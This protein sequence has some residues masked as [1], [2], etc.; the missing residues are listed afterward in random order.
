MPFQ[1]K[2]PDWHAEGVEP[3]ES[4]RNTGW[5]PGERPPAEYW[6]WQMNRTYKVLQE[7]QQKA[8]EKVEVQQAQQTANEAKAT[9]DAAQ[10]DL[11]A[12]ASATTDVHGATSAATPNTIIQR[13][14]SGRAKVAAPVE[15]DDIARKAEVD[16]HASRTDNPHNTTAAQVGALPKKSFS[17][18][19]YDFN[20]RGAGSFIEEIKN[21]ASITIQ[22]GPSGF[23]S[24]ALIQTEGSHAR[25][26][27]QIAIEQR[28]RIFFR[29][30]E[31]ASG[32]LTWGQWNELAIKNDYVRV[33]GYAA[34][35][36]SAN[37]YTVTLNPAPTSYTDG[38]CVA[39]KINTTNTGASTLNV[40][41]LGAKPIKKPN[42]NDVAAGNLKAG[43]IYTLRY[44]ATT[45][46]FILQGE[47]GDFSVGDT[48]TETRLLPVSG[49][50]GAEIWA[51]TDVAYG[52]SI[53][54]DS[55][56]YVYCAHDVSSGKAIRKLDSSGN[57][58]WSKTDVG[59][60]RGIAVDSAG[61][62]YCAHSVGSGGKAIR[63]LDSS[64]NEVWSKTDVAN[65]YGIAVD[66]AGYVYCAHYVDSGSKAIRK[67][68]SSGNEVWSK[69]D[70][71]NGYGIAVDSSGYVYCAHYVGIGGKAIRKL[72]S[73]G[74][75]VWSKTDV[76][77]GRG[78]AVDSAGNVYCAH[79]VSSGKVIRKLG[80]SGNEVWSKADVEYGRDV[81]V[82]STG[83]V[84][85]A[86][87]VGS[88]GKAIRKL[89]SSGNEVWSKTDVANGFG[90]AVDSSGYVYCAHYVDSGSKA[91]R[92]LD[93]NR[94]FQI[95][96]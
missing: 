95:L 62:V 61:N 94:Y 53:A 57:E 78:I 58:V 65:G 64:G 22:N 67:L 70:V 10:S 63:K 49:G 2:L 80:S 5:E 34:T 48:I 46:N 21:N 55:A 44:N 89:D 9:A 25:W 86:H 1:E 26:I 36:G 16:A 20:N 93:G 45:G 82:D 35:S 85:C 8:A 24:G 52:Y 50:M 60:G 66:S 6:N 41:G 56:G 15:S 88:G 32:V 79:G 7:L 19:I 69:T 76:G 42:G 33:P 87:S 75:E 30:G 54:V 13:D 23:S 71:A 59:Y 31:D 51:N 73:S 96:G 17:S 74:N 14:P 81:A 72:D 47:G 77:Y 38:M 43:S 68:D 4:K 37:N 40:N 83:N 91:I 84:Y 18:G 3:P 39:V 92:K 27:Q 90:I 28:G 12:H 11:S 29:I